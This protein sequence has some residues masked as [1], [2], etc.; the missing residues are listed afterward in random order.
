MAKAKAEKD[1]QTE[2]KALEIIRLIFQGKLSHDNEEAVKQVSEIIQHYSPGR[3][4]A[5]T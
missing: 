5:R 2:D 3:R 1:F 4:N